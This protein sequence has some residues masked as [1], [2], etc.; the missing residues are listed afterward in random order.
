MPILTG[1]VGKLSIIDVS[2]ASAAEATTEA[3]ATMIYQIDNVDHR[4]LDPNVS[5]VLSVGDFDTSYYD[6]GVNW[7]EG[8]VKLLTTGEGGLTLA[9]AWVTLQNVGKVFGWGIN[10]TLDAAETTEIGNDWKAR[11]PLAKSAGVTLSRYRFNT[12][13]DQKDFS[14]YQELGFAGKTGITETGLATPIQYYFKIALDGAGEVE[15]NI[16][17]AGDTT[18][19]AVIILINTALAAVDCE[20]GL[21]D[22]DF[23][24]TSYKDGNGSSI[25]LGAGTTGN[26]LFATLTDWAGFEAAVPGSFND[27]FILL[28][29][30]EDA[31]SGY[32]VKAL[33]SAFGLTKAI[34]TVDQE[35]LTFEAD[36]RIA[37]F[38]P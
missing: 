17:T 5:V 7:F 31:D 26:D 12:L 11:I 29:L 24:F 4:I 15:Y 3:G 30:F 37:Y 20:C 6:H 36:G 18:Y 25:G 13:F 27:L 19:A 32:W 8:K 34:N 9:V 23:R 38:V 22:G 33:R 28:K 16:T 1:K 2:T 14:G 35:A 21:V 10:L